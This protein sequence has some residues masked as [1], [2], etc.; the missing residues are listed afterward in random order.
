[1][2]WLWLLLVVMYMLILLFDMLFGEDW[3]NL[4]EVLVIVL[5]VDYWYFVV[6]LFFVLL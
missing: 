2:F 3:V 5:E 4:F 1:M 6:L